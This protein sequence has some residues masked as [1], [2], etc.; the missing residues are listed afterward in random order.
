[1]RRVRLAGS[2]FEKESRGDVRKRPGGHQ[3]RLDQGDD[4]VE[5]RP[6]VGHQTDVGVRRQMVRTSGTTVFVSLKKKKR[7]AATR[8]MYTLNIV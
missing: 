2:R 5:N 4:R 6:V 8:N 1:M 3:G 7:L